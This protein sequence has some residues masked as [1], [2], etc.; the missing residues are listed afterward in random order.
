MILQ[1]FYDEP[2]AQA[3]F[4][5]GCAQSGEALVI[6]PNRGVEQYVAAAEQAGLSNVLGE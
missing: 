6:D 4:L 1:R 5:V 2:L 3:S